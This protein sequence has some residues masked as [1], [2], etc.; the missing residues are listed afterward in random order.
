MSSNL[1]PTIISPGVSFPCGT[2]FFPL[3][4]RLLNKLTSTLLSPGVSFPCGTW[5]YQTLPFPPPPPPPPPVQEASTRRCTELAKEV[6]RLK[7]M[8]PER[9]ISDPYSYSNP[10]SHSNQRESSGPFSHT[11]HTHKHVQIL[12]CV[13][14]PCLTKCQEYCM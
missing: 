8:I 14:P 3:G 9:E 10:Y 2:C 1:H 12:N 4:V 7:A 11:H 5:F 6:W 13:E